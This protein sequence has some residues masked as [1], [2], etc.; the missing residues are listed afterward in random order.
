MTDK[1]KE[2]RVGWIYPCSEVFYTNAYGTSGRQEFFIY[3]TKEKL[4]RLR[5][6]CP[7]KNNCKPIKVLIPII[8]MDKKNKSQ[9]L[10]DIEWA[11]R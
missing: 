2:Q 9:V 5:K 10:K 8:K 4:M 6:H 1:I 7:C 11:L 3:N